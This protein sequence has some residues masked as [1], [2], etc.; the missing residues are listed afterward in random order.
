VGKFDSS[1]QGAKKIVVAAGDGRRTPAT[2][3]S[4]QESLGSVQS[5]LLSSPQ[6]VASGKYAD[7]IA[8]AK[9]IASGKKE[10]EGIAGFLGGT[11]TSALKGIGAVLGTPARVIA[12]AAKEI[13]DIAEGQ[14]PSPKEFISQSFDPDF[15]ASQF[16]PKSG[17]RLIDTV[18][19]FAVDVAGDPLTYV[20]LSSISS[21]SRAN[22]IALAAKAGELAATTTP[23][24]ANKLDDIVRFGE[25]AKLDDAERAALGIKTGLRYAFGGKDL[26]FKEGTKAGDISSKAADVL[27]RRFMATR[28]AIGDMP[29]LRR[30]Q[31]YVRPKSFGGELNK[32]GRG[33]NLDPTQVLRELAN[34]SGG[35]RGRAQRQ[36]FSQI[37]IGVGAQLIDELEKSPFRDTVYQV[38]DGSAERVRGVAPSPEEVDLANRIIAFR[39]SVRDDANI[40]ID[41]FNQRRGVNA[42]RVEY[43]EDYGSSRS[44]TPEAQAWINNRKFGTGKYDTEIANLLDIAPSDFVTGPT[45]M[46]ARKLTRQPDGSMP[47]WLGRKL[48]FADID[49]INAVTREVLGFD[50]YKTDSLNLLDDYVDSLARQTGR[51]AFVDRLFDYGTDVVDALLPKLV[52]DPKLL[53]PVKEALGHL[54]SIHRGLASAVDRVEGRAGRRMPTV[55]QAQAKL[56]DLSNKVVAAANALDEAVRVAQLRGDRIGAEA[57]EVLRP[58]EARVQEL[59]NLI[60]KG[61]ADEDQAM[62]LMK[63]L[64]VRM[65]PDLDDA[66]RPTTYA[67]LAKDLKE[68]SA[69]Q[70]EAITEELTIRAEMGDPRAARQL[71]AYKG[72]YTKEIKRVEGAVEQIR[73]ARES[74]KSAPSEL[75]KVQKELS[76]Q[77]KAFDDAMRRDPSMKG[78]RDARK[79]HARAVSA[80]DSQR[81]VVAK[82]EEWENFVRPALRD[83]VDEI[84]SGV[85]RTTPM[86]PGAG[87][88]AD[89]A[90]RAEKE[91]D[92]LLKKNVGIGASTTPIPQGVAQARRYAA[93]MGQQYDEIP[94][95]V[96][97]NPALTKQISDAY[98]ALP[99][100]APP[101][102][103]PDYEAFQAL[104]REVKE[105]YKYLT[106]ELG[107]RVEFTMDDP[108][109]DAADM[110]KDV[111][112]NKRLRVYADYLDHPVFT[113]DPETG[114]H[115]NAMFRAVHDYFGHAAGG[116]RFDRNGEEIAFL[117]H[118][119]MFSPE[120]SAAAATELRG[121]N[122]VLI[123]TGKFPEQK[124]YLLP[125]ELRGPQ[126]TMKQFVDDWA[127][128]GGTSIDI[129][130]REVLPPKGFVVG[131]GGEFEFGIPADLIR[132]KEDIANLLVAPFLSNPNVR[133]ELLKKNRWLGG[134]YDSD[135]DLFWVGVSTIIPS[136]KKAYSALVKNNQL[137]A[138]DIARKVDVFTIDGVA[139]REAAGLPLSAEE[140]RFRDGYTQKI[141]EARRGGGS[142]EFYRRPQGGTRSPF[143]MAEEQRATG[144]PE[145]GEQAGRVAGTF[146]PVEGVD[147]SQETNRID[148]LVAR[149]RNGKPLPEYIN[150]EWLEETNR[151][152]AAI[153]DASNLDQP[154]KSTW[155][156][157]LLDAKAKEAAL[158]SVGNQVKW[159]NDVVR[160]IEQVP[161]K[162][163]ADH[164]NAVREGWR[165]FEGLGVQLPQDTGRFLL[166]KIDEL[167]TADGIKEVLRI[168]DRYNRFFRVTAMLTPGFVVRNAYTAAFNNFVYG[169]TLQDTADAIRF[170]T[171]LHRR[172]ARAALAAVPEAERELYDAAYRSVL[173]SGAGQIREIATQPLNGKESRLLKTRAVKVWS[174]ANA[175]AE[176]GARMAMALRGIRNGKNIDEVAT[177]IA[178]YHFDY[179][180]LSKLDEFAKV[181]IPFW[182][183]ASRNIPLQLM[184]QISRPGMYRA[185]ES[186]KRNMPVDESI[187]LPSWLAEREPLGLGA[188]GV[189][190]PDLPQVDM[191]SQIAQL[192]DP[193]RLLSQLY[194]Q[195]KLPIELAGN[196]QL[197]LNIPFSETPQQVRGPLDVPAALVA[198]LTG[199]ATSTAEGPAISSKVAYAV[200]SA[201]PLL[202]L[203]QRLLPQG[204]GQ[205]KY[206]ERQLSSILAAVTGAPYRQVP[207][208]EQER[209]LRRR[210]FA[211]RDY[212]DDLKRR[213]FV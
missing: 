25:F 80:M 119:Q 52:D 91:L 64:H 179:T 190:N 17:N 197:G 131:L 175:D 22:R 213:G 113:I 53:G 170:A 134:W 94:G 158:A 182:T 85:A 115:E 177:D 147:V 97:A 60:A 31:D 23:S 157:V 8:K 137:A 116:S 72:A 40:F 81:A 125:P 16:I 1:I 38:I 174:N 149:V 141:E 121:Q 196:R 29:A 95:Y 67:G 75:K 63:S 146:Q 87:G 133:K 45:V 154:T 24:L 32:L 132:T 199:Q 49:E 118:I 105:Q 114:I 124:A 79:A 163:F 184:N 192:S 27:G 44:L 210:E 173:S 108:Y 127:A 62:T 135:N 42:Y 193:L 51:I 2:L 138:Y 186:L 212:L 55:P 88:Y 156:R 57:L 9:E 202:G 12:S 111:L 151:R 10:Q 178:R 4:V 109:P 187:I 90:V 167:A 18:V 101:V 83:A 181:F 78:V 82:A 103:S 47:T 172:G 153:N 107:I 211:L 169:A 112:F 117:R 160:T 39:N 143:T 145:G 14:L 69:E 98:N 128:N 102:G 33:S 126:T 122:S 159:A 50:F 28:A 20:G 166:G 43:L 204:G 198:A 176:T 155:E 161:N 165:A 183:F 123:I 86:K 188:G 152:L 207:Q 96:T 11:A 6:I 206:Q 13:S 150:N 73:T 21:A 129:T 3:G 41:E 7:S 34:Y 71:S 139:Q 36:M 19:G 142:A 144:I 48:E 195:Y 191:A 106:E 208:E 185:Y 59:T 37:E 66:S 189:L 93:R 15:F 120:A 136:E 5:A 65:Y 46:R 89:D 84:G 99:S 74:V 110:V 164:A 54:K 68:G 130:G 58:L 56:A 201:F 70:L 104:R 180:D 76:K 100:G 162:F 140:L 171:N 194:P 30:V 200:P 61:A 35:V 205:E 203:A 168:F 209:E 77:R 26:I 148:E 92:D